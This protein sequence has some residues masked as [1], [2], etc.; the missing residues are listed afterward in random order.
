[1]TI[2]NIELLHKFRYKSLIL[3]NLPANYKKLLF[4]VFNWVYDEIL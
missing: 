3:T 1:M 4:Y 2:F